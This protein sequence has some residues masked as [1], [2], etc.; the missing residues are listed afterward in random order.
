MP[1]SS[2]RGSKTAQIWLIF[3]YSTWLQ[4]TV[5]SIVRAL[6]QVV[7]S[8]THQLGGRTNEHRTVFV[9]YARGIQLDL[10]VM[11][12]SQR[13]G[14]PFGTV[15]LY[16]ADG[17]L[18]TSWEPPGGIGEKGAWVCPGPDRL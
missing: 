15:A 13:P 4:L 8:L 10:V 9:Q 2:G 3:P 1:C 5:S 14:L 7:D 12:A 11:P 6:D 18:A 16:D 17:R